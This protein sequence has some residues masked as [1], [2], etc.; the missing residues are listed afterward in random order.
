MKITIECNEKQ[1]YIIKDALDFYSRILMGQFSEFEN[2]FIGSYNYKYMNE[3]NKLLMKIRDYI[4][5]ELKG[6]ASWGIFNKKCPENSKI[7]YDIIQVLRHEMIKV[8]DPEKKY[9]YGVDCNEPLQTSKEELIN[10][11]VE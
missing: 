8:R 1:A 5:P 4:Y 10:V 11:K 2:L 9:G 7:A 6:Y 3:I